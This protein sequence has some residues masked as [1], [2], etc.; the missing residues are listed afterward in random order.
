M[1]IHNLAQKSVLP[2]SGPLDQFWSPKIHGPPLSTVVLT[3][4][5]F[6]SHKW[7]CFSILT[8]EKVE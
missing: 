3:G 8:A 7:S 4:P 2:K 5:H 6:G 1:K